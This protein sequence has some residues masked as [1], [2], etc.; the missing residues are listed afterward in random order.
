M[1]F[2]KR[3]ESVLS[4]HTEKHRMK[5]QIIKICEVWLHKQKVAEHEA[6]T[7]AE[8]WML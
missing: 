1:H 4:H 6:W 2:H 7:G 5:I 8:I 3:Y